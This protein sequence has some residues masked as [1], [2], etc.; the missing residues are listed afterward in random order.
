M[1]HRPPSNPI[2]P[3]TIVGKRIFT[4]RVTGSEPGLTATGVISRATDASVWVG[5]QRYRL[6][7]DGFVTRI[8]DSSWSRPTYVIE[9]TPAWERVSQQAEARV[10]ELAAEQAR[11]AVRQRIDQRLYKMDLASLEATEK[12]IIAMLGAE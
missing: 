6:D 2:D 4:A 9:G 3:T 12:A 11:R 5:F 1:V 7:S 10:A 8:G